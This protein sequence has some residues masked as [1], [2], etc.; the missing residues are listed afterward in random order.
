M[1]DFNLR[2]FRAMIATAASIWGERFR[3]AGDSEAHSVYVKIGQEM[4]GQL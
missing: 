1:P 3:E 2:S 4:A